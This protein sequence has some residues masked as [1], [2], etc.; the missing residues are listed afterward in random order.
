MK[1]WQQPLFEAVGESVFGLMYCVKNNRIEFLIQTI[2]E[3]GCFDKIEIGPSVQ[4]GA[5]C[6]ERNVVTKLFYDK[7]EKKEGI[8]FTGVFSEEGGRFY[9][10]Q[11]RN[12][13]MEVKEEELQ[14][15]PEGFFWVD[16]QTLNI[17]IQFN[18]C[19]NIQLRNLLSILRL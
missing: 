16:Y 10:E 13:L 5:N 8:I 14:E 2:A 1:R 11:N 4:L 17:L 19:L 3:V 6:Q 12:V 18:N 15:I 9:H 7:M